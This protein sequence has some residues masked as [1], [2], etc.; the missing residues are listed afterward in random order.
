MTHHWQSALLPPD[1]DYKGAVGL[2][3]HDIIA[4]NG[5]ETLQIVQDIA[6]AAE[7]AARQAEA[8][9]KQLE[10]IC[11]E[12]EKVVRDAF[13]LYDTD[14]SGWID[15]AELK[16]MLT[17]ELCEPITELELDQAMLAIDLDGNGQIEFQELLLWMAK[18]V[19]N[20]G[21]TSTKITLLRKSLRARRRIRKL[22]EIVADKMP[23]KSIPPPLVVPGHSSVLQITMED[24]ERKTP[25]LFRYIAEVHGLEWV[26]E[27]E[28]R[29][30][31]SQVKSVFSEL[32]IKKWNLGKLGHEFYYDYDKFIFDNIEYE[33]RWHIQSLRYVYINVK[34]NSEYG[35][36][37]R[38]LAL[39]R[40]EANEAFMKIDVDGSGGID[41]N[42]FYE[43]VLLHLSE[44]MSRK[45]AS[46]AFQ[47]IDLNGNGELDLEEFFTWYGSQQSQNLKYSKKTEALRSTLKAGKGAAI[48]GKLTSKLTK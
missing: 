42:E 6:Q 38:K 3:A 10:E 28:R 41:E 26:Y 22:R 37:P 40:M 4:A 1:V 27:D 48:T 35:V 23:E 32:F 44:P 39:L 7:V 43:M 14:N 19:L 5:W 31:I 16:A 15:R 21:K 36:D 24:F 2:L 25:V 11:N 20:G 13:E 45:Q 33:C 46:L 29:M 30:S 12:N 18:E 9:A 47:E 34:D 8:V 17:Q